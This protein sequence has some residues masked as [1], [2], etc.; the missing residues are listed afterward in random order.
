AW[1]Q[2]VLPLS[3]RRDTLSESPSVGWSEK[4]ERASNRG[5]SRY[6]CP[7]VFPC[8]RNG[9]A[10]SDADRLHREHN[11]RRSTRPVS[12]PRIQTPSPSSR[13]PCS[14]HAERRR[15]PHCRGNAESLLAFWWR[16]HRG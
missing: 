16:A 6:S 2:F 12:G 15:R 10:T 13:L 1:R 4:N 11:I 5:L 14:L 9:S 7:R 8:S 3:S